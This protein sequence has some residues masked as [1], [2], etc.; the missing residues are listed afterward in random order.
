MMIVILTWFTFWLKQRDSLLKV[1]MNLLLLLW[2]V[3]KND[4]ISEAL[5]KVA[6]TK[7]RNKPQPVSM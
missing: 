4:D 6:Y 1:G 7:V 5:P 2:I 3:T